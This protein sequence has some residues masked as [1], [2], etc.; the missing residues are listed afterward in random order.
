MTKQ[1]TLDIAIPQYAKQ[2]VEALQSNQYQAYIVGGY[3]R[4]YFAGRTPKDIDIVTDATPEQIKTIFQHKCQLIGKRFRLAHVRV[5]KKIVEVSTFRACASLGVADARIR[6][7]SDSGMILRDNLYGSLEEDMSRRDFTVNSLYYDPS[8][9]SL[10]DPFNGVNDVINKTIR[11]IGDTK[12]RLQEDPLR[13]L[14]AIRFSCKLGFALEPHIEQA[15][16]QALPKLQDIPAGRLFDEYTK[17]FLHGHGQTTFQQLCQFNAVSVLFPETMPYLND[18][19]TRAFINQ[20][21]QNTDKRFDEGKS[22]H[23]GFLIAVFLWPAQCQQLD[24]LKQEQ[25]TTTHGLAYEAASL[26]LQRQAQHTALPKRFVT[27]IRQVWLMQ[28]AL[29]NRKPKQVMTLLANIRFRA[30]YDFFVLRAETGGVKKQQDIANWWTTIQTQNKQGQ[31]K[32]IEKLCI[33]RAS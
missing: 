32:M 13:L 33:K 17:L 9:R 5:Q 23:P 6:S 26:V 10:L 2:I 7:H 27:M 3:L 18:Q 29:A 25:S 16:P 28:S 14:R 31:M 24:I 11:F 19:Q 15:V 8:T 21:L 22:I 30:A 20:A 4:D 1:K 12:K